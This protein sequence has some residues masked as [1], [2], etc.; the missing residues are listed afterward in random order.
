[1]K[2]LTSVSK[3]LAKVTDPLKASKNLKVADSIFKTP[4]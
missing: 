4:E 2:H 3:D 1:M